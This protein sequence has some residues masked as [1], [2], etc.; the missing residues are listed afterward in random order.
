MVYLSTLSQTQFVTSNGGGMISELEG[1][2]RG[3]G[4]VCMLLSEVNDGKPVGI[5]GIRVGFE[6][7]TFRIQ[8]RS[9]NNSTASFSGTLSLESILVC[10]LKPRKSKYL[11]RILDICNTI[12]TV[13]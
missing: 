1:C 11:T 7:G 6:R 8:N 12:C 5:A 2:G 13:L 9:A 10:R 4:V 3:H